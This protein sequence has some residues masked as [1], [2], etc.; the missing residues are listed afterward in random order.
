MAQVWRRYL[1][2]VLKKSL[3][4]FLNVLQVLF[5]KAPHYIAK[6]TKA[7]KTVK[8]K[9]LENKMK[10]VAELNQKFESQKRRTDEKIRQDFERIAELDQQ[11]KEKGIFTSEKV[12]ELK[13]DKK[14]QKAANT[15]KNYSIR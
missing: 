7:L 12:E 2:K 14:F 1:K 3:K 11:Y 5:Q 9:E 6:G 10:K 4:M 15:Y 8:C 13:N